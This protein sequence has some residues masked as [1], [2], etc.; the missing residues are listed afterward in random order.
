MAIWYASPHNQR[1]VEDA[2]GPADVP[3]APAQNADACTADY[4]DVNKNEAAAILQKAKGYKDTP[5]KWGGDNKDGID[6]SHL[7]WRA[8]TEALPAAKFEFIDTA[9]MKDSPGLRKLD[10]KEAPITGDV[11]LFAHHVGF[12]DA[13]PPADQA[14]RSLFSAEGSQTKPTPGVTWG[15]PEWFPGPTTYFRVRMPCK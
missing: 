9:G 6:C 5:Y 10:A 11:V 3:D 12:Y 7:V 2:V 14:G 15:K 1:L 4:R 8:I 13:T